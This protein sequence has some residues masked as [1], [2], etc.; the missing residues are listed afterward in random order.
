MDSDERY[1]S[2]V[3]FIDLLFN[4]LIGFV[5]LFILAFIMINPI[6]KKGDIVVPAE[7]III[8]TWPDELGDDIDLWV[9]DQNEN[10][11]GFNRK[12]A[13]IMYLDRD[14]LGWMNDKS[15]IDG[16][17]ITI[18]LNREVVTI[19]GKAP[20]QYKI[21]VHFY[22]KITPDDSNALNL[23]SMNNIPITVT[24]TKLNP[25]SEVY[26]QTLIISDQ[27]EIKNFRSF[28]VDKH[29][30]V[31]YIQEGIESIIPLNQIAPPRFSSNDHLN[32]GK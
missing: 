20:N 7:F 3:A 1:K 28:T 5:Y 19:R 18:R 6:A 9:K 30:N 12:D 8:L 27:G 14:D 31:I 17:E 13:G 29:N 26:K 2:N 23:P 11:V 4:V 10:L 15:T 21:S 24:V 25:Y 16:E 22:R 32:K